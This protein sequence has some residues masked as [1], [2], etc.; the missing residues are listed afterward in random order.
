MSPDHM[1][2][3]HWKLANM[4][5]TTSIGYT[6]LMSTAISIHYVAVEA[7]NH[8]KGDECGEWC[9]TVFGYQG[10]SLMK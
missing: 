4:S 9:E 3:L 8:T 2:D 5:H 7:L 10:I 1:P 6:E